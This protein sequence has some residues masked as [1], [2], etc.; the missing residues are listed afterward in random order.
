[1]TVVVLMRRV[2]SMR[3]LMQMEATENSADISEYLDCVSPGLGL[4]GT[5]LLD[6]YRRL[7]FLRPSTAM[8]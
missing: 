5:V 7:F 2:K 3:R 8:E 6:R 4:L 1:M